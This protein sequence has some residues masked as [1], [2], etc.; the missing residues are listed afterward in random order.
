[1]P[2]RR[3]GG[4]EKKLDTFH[5]T[6]GSF[7]QNALSAGTAAVTIANALHLP[8]TLVRIRGEWTASIDAAGA[9]ARHVAVGVGIILVPEGTGTTVLWSPITDGDAPWIWWDHA[10]LLHEELVTDVVDIP[11]MSAVR[12]VIDNKAMRRVRNQEIQFV[13]EN[14]TIGSASAINVQGAARFL[15]GS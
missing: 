7:G 4:F 12:R 13:A 10:I 1:M 8:E 9:P 11:V 3:S 6:Y 14:A 15:S 2:R 5:W